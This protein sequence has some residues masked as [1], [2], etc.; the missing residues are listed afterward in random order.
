[1]PVFDAQVRIVI[2]VK[3]ESYVAVDGGLTESETVALIDL[4]NNL[5]ADTED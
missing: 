2:V 3:P 5:P 1:V 4:L